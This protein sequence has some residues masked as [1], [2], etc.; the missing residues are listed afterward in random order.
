MMK[1]CTLLQRQ[2]A[3]EAGGAT[4]ASGP[5]ITLKYEDKSIMDDAA[6]LIIHHVKRQTG[7][8]C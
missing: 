6:S 8:F 1:Q 5:H 7:R 4:I 3:V 2:E